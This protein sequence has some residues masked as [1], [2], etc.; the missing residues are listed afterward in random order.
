M[1]LDESVSS[2]EREK[3][4]RDPS[5][6]E[7][8]VRTEAKGTFTFSGLSV[9][10]DASRITVTDSITKIPATSFTGRNTISVRVLGSSTI[11][12]GGSTVTASD[13]YPKFQNE[14]IVLDI[15]DD[16]SVALYAICS[17]GESCELAILE[18]A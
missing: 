12:V 4:F 7:V 9:G 10:L 17:I 14:E 3:F 16:S 15:T 2:L 8:T 18:V 11:Y 5:T 13:G 1:I 6:N